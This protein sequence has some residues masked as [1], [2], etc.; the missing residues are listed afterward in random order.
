MANSTFNASGVGAA[1]AGQS[2]GVPNGTGSYV[3]H[4]NSD[5]TVT[6]RINSNLTTTTFD[7]SGD[8]SHKSFGVELENVSPA[9]GNDYLLF[10]AYAG[11]TVLFEATGT[12]TDT[13][14]IV[15]G[16]ETSHK[17]SAQNGEAIYL[18]RV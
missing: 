7:V 13:L 2:V 8:T 15:T 6:G 18:A 17:S 16:A 5:A 12:A 11:A 1:A 10:T 9:S 14:T 4:N 3:F